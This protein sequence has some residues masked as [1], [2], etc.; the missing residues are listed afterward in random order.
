MVFV[1]NSVS[2]L[3]ES[4]RNGVVIAGSHAGLNVALY[5]ANAGLRGVIL[6]DAG[7]AA[8]GSGYAALPVL[9]DVG[10]AA[11]TVSRARAL[12]G[13]GLEMVRAPISQV[14]DLARACGVQ[15]GMAGAYAADLLD[16][17]AANNLMLTLGDPDSVGRV[18]LGDRVVGCASICQVMPSDREVVLVIGSHPTLLDYY[19]DMWPLSSLPV[20][21]FFHDGGAGASDLYPV[22]VGRVAK[23][24]NY[25]VPAATIAGYSAEIGNPESMY[26]EGLLNY[27]N[28]IGLERGLRRGMSCLEAVEL[29]QK[30][31]SF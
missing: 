24:A 15:L 11:V 28:E 10:I 20:A 9:N 3:D 31:N 29:C 18:I 16:A 5:V 13:V 21:A 1:R 4:V 23:L 30:V 19:S 17:R 8:H 27:V 26:R 7:N 14:N 12:I 6:N 25:Q 22:C 2:E